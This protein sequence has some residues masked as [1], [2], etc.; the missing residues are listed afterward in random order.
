MK[1]K[2]SSKTKK[3]KKSKKVSRFRRISKSKRRCNNKLRKT[4]KINMKGGAKFFQQI[5]QALFL[6]LALTPISTYATQPLPKTLKRNND[7]DNNDNNATNEKF[8]LVDNAIATSEPALLSNTETIINDLQNNVKPSVKIQETMKTMKSSSSN[9]KTIIVLGQTDGIGLVPNMLHRANLTVSPIDCTWAGSD[10]TQFVSL[11]NIVGTEW[12]N[13]LEDLLCIQKLVDSAPQGNAVQLAGEFDMAVA[14]QGNFG[15]NPSQSNMS[16]NDQNNIADLIKKRVVEGKI[17]ATYFTEGIL[18]SAG[19]VSPIMVDNVFRGSEY[20]DIYANF[21]VKFENLIKSGETLPK[22][23]EKAKELWEKIQQ[24]QESDINDVNNIYIIREFNAEF[25]GLMFSDTINSMLPSLFENVKIDKNGRAQFDTRGTSRGTSLPL[26]DRSISYWGRNIAARNAG[27]NMQVVGNPTT[28]GSRADNVP[29][30]HGNVVYA[31]SIHTIN[32]ESVY[33]NNKYSLGVTKININ[34]EGEVINISFVIQRPDGSSIDIAIV[35]YH[36]V[37][38][39][40]LWYSF[41]RL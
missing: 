11:G 28:I 32:D 35:D 16:L 9:Y 2:K 24:I 18:F 15:L 10:N 3:L 22:S 40:K 8:F 7:N 12:N 31:N 20:D 19:G 6:F 36:R 26:H 23:Y 30:S 4:R 5:L 38:L 37:T 34:N 21:K 25:L 39:N 41:N 29:I 27:I 17:Q 13:S 1:F 33:A 14:I